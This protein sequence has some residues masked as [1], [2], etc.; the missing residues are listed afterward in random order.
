M[1]REGSIDFGCDVGTKTESRG[2]E[3]VQS[4]PRGEQ[5]KDTELCYFLSVIPCTLT[6]LPFEINEKSRIICRDTI[7]SVEMYGLGID[8]KYDPLDAL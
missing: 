8:L 3:E 2:Q 7:F 4:V 1:S 5:M 6:Y